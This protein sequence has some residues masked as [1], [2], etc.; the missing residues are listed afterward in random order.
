MVW[1]ASVICALRRSAW[2]GAPVSKDEA[3]VASAIC[4]SRR[5]I[6]RV[7]HLHSSSRALR[8]TGGA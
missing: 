3:S 8:R 5:L 4:A 1:I 6:W 7:A 2:R